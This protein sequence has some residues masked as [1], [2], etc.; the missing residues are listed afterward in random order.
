MSKGIA[1]GCNVILNPDTMTAL[2]DMSFL[3][4]DNKCHSF[5]ASANGY[6]RG[7]GFGLV[8]LKRLKDA[9]RD[10]DTIRGVIRATGI[11]Q[12]GRTPSITQPSSVAQE[13]LIKDTYEA[14][15]LSLGLTR[16]F[17]AHG[18]GTPVGD[19][20]EAQAIYRSFQEPLKDHSIYIGA[21]K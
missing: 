5:D 9:L 11:N 13:T 2:T 4:P 3:S 10:H 6:S 19:P 17:E 16:F 8:V 20:L 15:G 18:T 7:E 1:G 14:G 12:D 21:V